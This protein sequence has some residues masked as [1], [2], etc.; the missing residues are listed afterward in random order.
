[1]IVIVVALLLPTA[2]AAKAPTVPT[3]A[4]SAI[5]SSEARRCPRHLE[6][7]N[8]PRERLRAHTPRARSE[9]EDSVPSSAS[10]LD[11]ALL[12]IHTRRASSSEIVFQRVKTVTIETVARSATPTRT[13]VRGL[14]LLELIATAEGGVS[15]SQLA[16]LAQLDKATTSRLLATLRET[17]W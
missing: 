16:E 10:A 1:M 9:E 14:N 7:M 12:N 6:I 11:R 13:L 8:P 5:A 17:G 4:T 2:V 3:A 15:L